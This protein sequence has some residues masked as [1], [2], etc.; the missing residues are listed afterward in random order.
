MSSRLFLHRAIRTSAFAALIATATLSAAPPANKA[1]IAAP[2]AEPSLKLADFRGSPPA[3]GTGYKIDATVPVSGYDGQFTVQTDLGEIKVDGVGMLKQRVGEV[4]PS[5][6]LKKLS[7]SQ[8]FVDA[9]SKS[10]ANSAKAVG[11]AVANPIDTAQAVPAGVGRF[12]K[13]IGKSI[14]N[15]VD[16]SSNGDTGEAA[17]DALG[18]NDAKR[19]LAKKVGVDPYT[20][21]PY[22]AARLDELAKAAFAGGVSLDVVLAVSTAGAA[23][24]LSATKTVSNLAWDLPPQDVRERNAKDLAALKVDDA[25]SAKLLNNRWYT[26][27]MALSFVEAMKALGVS[28]G[29][30]AFA[31]LA[32]GSQNESEARFF[33]AQLRLAGRYAKEGDAIVA[34]E[35][36]G[37]IGAFRSKSGKLLIPAPVDY[38]SW[39]EGVKTFVEGKKGGAG[40]RVVWISGSA[41]PLAAAQL[42]E[43]GW[44]MRD[45][46]ALD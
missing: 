41:S 6:E 16:T 5:L 33:V 11:K 9:L 18:V 28:T 4:G 43:N 22:V 30:S 46:V 15:T 21:N 36:T 42:R 23:A 35:S 25:T 39:T 10:A 38:L 8:V 2:E 32:A 1:S 14:E 27:T 24:A 31:A 26:P 12:F 40:E 17:K 13:S 19:H 20:T 7:S 45:N 3:S 37:K 34:M 29:S 44:Q